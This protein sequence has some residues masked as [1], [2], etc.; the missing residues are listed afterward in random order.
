MMFWDELFPQNIISFSTSFK[1]TAYT[2]RYP[3]KIRIEL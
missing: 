1:L 2:V 3:L